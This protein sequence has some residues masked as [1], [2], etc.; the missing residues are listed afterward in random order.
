MA[1]WAPRCPTKHCIAAKC[2]AVPTTADIRQKVIDE[3]RPSEARDVRGR[4]VRRAPDAG[5]VVL[6]DPQGR[7]YHPLVQRSDVAL[8]ARVRLNVEDLRA[9]VHR[10]GAAPGPREEG[11]AAP[12]TAAGRDVS[13]VR[14]E[15]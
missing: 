6:H 8:L 11:C 3:S 14:A 12:A 13:K 9:P 15:L 5:L 1:S 2:R 7:S 10:G 4:R